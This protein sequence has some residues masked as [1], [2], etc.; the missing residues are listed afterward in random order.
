MMNAWTPT[1]SARPGG[2][3]R[4]EVV[5]RARRRSAARARPRRGTGRGSRAGRSGPAPRPAPRAGSP[6]GPPGS[7]GRPPI[8]G[9]P[10]PRPDAEQPAARERVQRLDGLVARR[11]AG[12]ANGSSQLSTRCWTWPNRLYRT[13]EPTMNSDQRRR[14]R[15]TA[16]RSPRTASRGRPRRTAARR[17][18]PAG[19]RRSPSAIAT[20]A[21]IGARY[22]IGGSGSARSACS[23][24]RA[25][26]GS[27]TGTPR[28][29]HDEDHLQQLRRLAGQRADRQR[30]AR[31]VDVAAEHER[32]QQQ[33][34]A[35]RRPRVLVGPQPGVRA[36]REREHRDR[37]SAR[38]A[39]SRA[40]AGR[41]RAP[42]RRTA[43]TTR[44]CGSRC[45]SSRPI[46][47]SIA[48]AG[49]QDLVGAP[50]GEHERAGGRRTA[51]RDR[52]AGARG[53]GGAK[54]RPVGG[55]AGV[56]RLA[57]SA[58]SAPSDAAADEQRQR[59]RGRAASSSVRPRAR[60]DPPA[61]S[62]TGRA[63]A[64]ALTRGPGRGGTG[65]RPPGARRRSRAAA[66]RSTGTPLTNVPFVLSRSSTYQAR[67]RNVSTAWSAD[68]ERVVDDDR[69]V[70]VAA[71]RRDGVE[72]ERRPD[73]RLALRRGEDDQPA[74]LRRARADAAR[75]SRSRTRDDHEQERVQERRRNR[76]L[77]SHSVR[78]NPSTLSPG[79][80]RRRG[81]CR[82]PGRG[83]PG[84]GRSR[85]PGCR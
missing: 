17:R 42:R 51:R 60:A 22:G 29:E 49:Q 1:T 58:G 14:R 69:V 85:R 18:G 4:P 35:R 21:T 80:F 76:S 38:G 62:R 11:P 30:Q 25:A 83:R 7:A 41:G 20:I 65:P 57:G 54:S 71:E 34:D 6:C 50:A 3:Q 53:S 33:R 55:R 28:E 78:T 74:E 10:A 77:T 56:E 75:R 8:V 37:R 84:R 63:W 15:T 67:P 43:A 64:T 44:S 5:V 31:A 68:R 12:R 23:R 52:R 72:R 16:G 81:P 48:V 27:P 82:R 36:D 45:I 59:R 79:A 70:D 9:S 39:A 26:T 40:G 61:G 13:H 47:P 46:P 24:R 73:R 19:R 32:Q 66:T 2:E